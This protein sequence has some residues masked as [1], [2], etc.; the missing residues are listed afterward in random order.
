[1]TVERAS[2]K[3]LISHINSHK[4]YSNYLFEKN[5][6]TREQKDKFVYNLDKAKVHSIHSMLQ[7]QEYDYSTNKMQEYRF[8]ITSSPNKIRILKS[9]SES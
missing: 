1:M 6:I 8:P 2:L 4:R 3:E 5:I 7:V 9:L